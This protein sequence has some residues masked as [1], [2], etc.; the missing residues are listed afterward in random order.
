MFSSIPFWASV[1]TNPVNGGPSTAK[2]RR[3][4]ALWNVLQRIQL[5][6]KAQPPNKDD[7]GSHDAL[8][9]F[10]DE[11]L[12][13]VD[14][15]A[16]PEQATY[17][18]YCDLTTDRKKEL[19]AA[20]KVQYEP[21]E[22]ADD[23]ERV[24]FKAWPRVISTSATLSVEDDLTWYERRVGLTN[25]SNTLRDSIQSPL[26]TIKNKCCSTRLEAWSLPT[27]EIRRSISTGW[28]EKCIAWSL[29]AADDSCSA[30]AARACSSSS[31]GCHLC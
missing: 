7:Q 25:A 5:K 23:L 4:L 27:I 12:D 6:L 30:P 16:R 28:R 31:N 15:L 17:I 26:D 14:V 3:G 21:L 8:L 13:T 24:L 18:R 19:A 20:L 2:S 9:R 11:I 10:G 1:R 22:V 29:R